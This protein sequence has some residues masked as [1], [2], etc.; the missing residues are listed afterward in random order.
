[1][2]STMSLATFDHH[3]LEQFTRTFEELFYAADARSMT[4]YYT[5]QAH[6]MGDG[7]MP[8]QGHDPIEQFWRTAID[9]AAAVGARR[10][11]QL[12]ESHF[13]GELG[14][15][16][17]TVAVEIPGHMGRTAWDTTVWRQ[18]ADGRW[19][20]AVDISTLLPSDPQDAS[21]P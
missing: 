20:I 1:M 10:T 2:I 14:Y 11:I 16:L 3:E 8:I 12:H 18:G 15:A 7:M 21:Q 4:S 6:L 13:S 17:C 19:R 9:R 5:D